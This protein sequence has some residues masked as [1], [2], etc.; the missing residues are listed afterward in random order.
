VNIERRIKEARRKEKAEAKRE[1][2][3]ARRRDK[4]G[5]GSVKQ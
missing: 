1:K 3:Q 4:A 2:R 5:A